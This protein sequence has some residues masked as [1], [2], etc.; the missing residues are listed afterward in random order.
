MKK[1]VIFLFALGAT[2][3]STKYTKAA[4]SDIGY[5]LYDG[6]NSTSVVSQPTSNY[7]YQSFIT[8]KN[9]N[10]YHLETLEEISDDTFGNSTEH[11]VYCYDESYDLVNEKSEA[12][13]FVVDY[14]MENQINLPVYAANT[15]IAV[16]PGM[17]YEYTI[18]LSTTS[19]YSITT[20]LSVSL[21]QSVSSETS[22]TLFDCLKETIST[23]L[24]TT[25]SASISAS[26]SLTYSITVGEKYSYTNTSSDTYRY[27][28]YEKRANCV[29]HKIFI[30]K[31]NYDQYATCLGSYYKYS[32]AS[33]FEEGLY[34]YEKDEYGYL[35]R[36]YTFSSDSSTIY[37]D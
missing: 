4:A 14:V 22:A 5:W 13:Y 29:A 2:F 27:L 11:N 24:E 15:F 37:L 28:R 20:D 26:T 10:F 36:I 19:A 9:Y 33:S 23:E 12:T 18:S 21:S 3:L 34:I 25:I 35:K 32:N 7:N 31:Y 8:G 16:G 30:F 6:D 1:S 17:S